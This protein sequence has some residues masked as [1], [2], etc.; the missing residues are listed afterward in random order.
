MKLRALVILVLAS[1]LL[2]AAIAPA[3][4]QQ[5]PSVSNLEPF[6]AEANFMS[7]PGYLRWLLFQQNGN[8]ITYQEAARMVQQQTGQAP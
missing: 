5:V 4:A 7:L 3:F 2:A 6:S 1:V 8:W